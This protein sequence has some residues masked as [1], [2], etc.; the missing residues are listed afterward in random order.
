MEEKIM[1]GISNHAISSYCDAYSIANNTHI[2]NL[3]TSGPVPVVDHQ[4]ALEDFGQCVYDLTHV[5]P[6]AQ[7]KPQSPV[8]EAIANIVGPQDSK[9]KPNGI[10]DVIS[11]SLEHIQH[12]PHEVPYPTSVSDASSVICEMHQGGHC[13]SL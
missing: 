11:S 9:P 7:E 10:G 4:G 2:V 6:Q 1:N 5:S 12:T 13:Y 3:P 8:S